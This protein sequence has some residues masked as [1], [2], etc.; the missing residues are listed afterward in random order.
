MCN[1]LKIMLRNLHVGLAHISAFLKIRS[2]EI[3][4]LVQHLTEADMGFA[5]RSR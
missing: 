4:C 1:F 2:Y 5:C 3:R